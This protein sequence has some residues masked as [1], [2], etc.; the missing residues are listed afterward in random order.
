MSDSR[1]GGRLG[2]LP[3]AALALLAAVF[4][5]MLFFSRKAPVIHELVPEMAAPGDLVIISGEYF[6]R[7]EREGSL[8]LAGEIPPPS[9]IKSWT[10]KRIEFQIPSDAVSGLVTVSNSQGTSTG[11]LFTNTQLIPT[12]LDSDADIASPILWS[13]SPSTLRSGQIVT[14]RGR[15]FG[16]G[17]RNATLVI[18]NG[19]SGPRWNLRPRDSV[20]WSD[21]QIQFWLPAGAS[22]QSSVTIQ[23]PLGTSLPLTIPAESP[24]RFNEPRSI[25]LEL[26]TVVHLS[27]GLSA[28]VWGPVP[29]V[30]SGTQ[31]S[32]SRVSP[33]PVTEESGLAF[34]WSGAASDVDRQVDYVLHLT[35]WAR[36]WS[37]LAAGVV[38]SDGIPRGG[39]DGAR[40]FWSPATTNLRKIISSWGLDTSDPWL[41]LN[42]IH[43]GLTAKWASD[44]HLHSVRGPAVQLT[45]TTLGSDEA[46]VL[47]LA[48]ASM[49]GLTV[50]PV[51]GLLLGGDGIPVTRQWGEVWIPGAGWIPWDP[52]LDPPGKLDNRHFAFL[53]GMR[54]LPRLL[55]ASQSGAVDVPGWG[56][57]TAVEATGEPPVVNWSLVGVRN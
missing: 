34:L 53:S 56:N 13:S 26:S 32:V 22:S 39:D 18:D 46:S 1:N 52:F 5:L 15:G 17:T 41:K 10:D 7:T 4:L 37:G 35:T 3:F 27:A 29:D 43:N 23:T 51:S 42:R 20:L 11:V 31:W 44:S 24:L 54:S 38:G 14:L 50:R 40:S 55:S 6:G 36:E 57:R 49:S 21:R 47:G 9:L 8:S 2:W 12:V 30:E 25:D 19:A 33:V 48:V 28:A 16:S 45:S